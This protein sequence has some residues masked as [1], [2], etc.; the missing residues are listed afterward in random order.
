MALHRGP[1]VT[2]KNLKGRDVAA[3]GVL[4]RWA[5]IE[6]EVACCY[7]DRHDR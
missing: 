3:R 5:A 2:L 4:G 6:L 1:V 7:A